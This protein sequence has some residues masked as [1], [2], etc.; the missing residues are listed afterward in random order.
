MI[1]VILYYF[2]N[3]L[4]VQNILTLLKI[5]LTMTYSCFVSPETKPETAANEDMTSPAKSMEKKTDLFQLQKVCLH[6]FQSLP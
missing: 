6:R 2:L 1:F 5:C 3:V 4:Y